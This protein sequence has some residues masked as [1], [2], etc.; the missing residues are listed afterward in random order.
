MF[1]NNVAHEIIECEV[2]KKVTE[3][4]DGELGNGRD[5]QNLNVKNLY[6]ITKM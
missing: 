3:T 6:H 5:A 1:R 4:L 2:N